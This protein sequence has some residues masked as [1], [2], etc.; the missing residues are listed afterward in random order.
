HNIRL[1]HSRQ[2]YRWTV[3]LVSAP[4]A[5][6][7]GHIGNCRNPLAGSPWIS[8]IMANPYLDWIW[9][10]YSIPKSS[11][12]LSLQDSCSYFTKYILQPTDIILSHG[13]FVLHSDLTLPLTN[14]ISGMDYFL[15]LASH[16]RGLQQPLFIGHSELNTLAAAGANSTLA[17]QS[18][19]VHNW[20][21]IVAKIWAAKYQ[22]KALCAGDLKL[23]S[24]C[25]WTS[26]AG[27]IALS[28]PL[29]LRSKLPR[30]LVERFDITIDPSNVKAAVA[31]EWP[32]TSVPLLPVPVN[33]PPTTPSPHS[34]HSIASDELAAQWAYLIKMPLDSS[35]TVG[36]SDGQ[37]S[38]RAELLRLIFDGVERMQMALT[39]IFHPSLTQPACFQVDP[40]GQLEQLL[41]GINTL[42]RLTMAWDALAERMRRASDSFKAP[43]LCTPSLVPAPLTSSP[44]VI[45]LSSTR[46]S[47][48]ASF[49]SSFNGSTT[50]E[51]LTTEMSGSHQSASPL[52]ST[53]GQATATVRREMAY[54]F[55]FADLPYGA[56]PE[57]EV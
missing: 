23:T 45:K 29:E 14:I 22:L 9:S 20:V 19:V 28:L 10:Q 26:Q 4:G 38:L 49:Q 17:T 3:T 18:Q 55:D 47:T 35:W 41:R 34:S 25:S 32:H 54:S 6:Q 27:R 30:D 46:F 8:V 7:S 39:D 56:M 40:H 48:P 5:L 37:C 21:L 51:R 57:D 33:I 52:N 13:G 43:S 15:D 2:G 1:F 42:D 36:N 50:H 12:Q 53:R 24:L 16:Y 44:P 31:T 11:K